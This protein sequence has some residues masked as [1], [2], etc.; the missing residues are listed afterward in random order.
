MAAHDPISKFATEPP[1]VAEVDL[2]LVEGETLGLVG[3]NG[4]GKSTLL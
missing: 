2:Q 1:I 4:S 3:P